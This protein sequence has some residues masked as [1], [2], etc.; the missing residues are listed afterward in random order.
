MTYYHTL[1]ITDSMDR[2]LKEIQEKWPKKT[3]EGICMEALVNKSIMVKWM[4]IAEEK[5]DDGFKP[6]P[7]CGAPLTM[8]DV[9]FCDEEGTPCDHISD[10]FAQI[11]GIS[12]NCG[13]YFNTAVEGLY[14]ELE[15]LYEGGKWEENF[16]ALANR[17]YKVVD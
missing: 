5:G 11:A 14:D 12:C 10:Q 15:D 16:K 4:N 2:M 3:I 13:Y 7:I 1:K 8:R 17:R 6:C 9:F